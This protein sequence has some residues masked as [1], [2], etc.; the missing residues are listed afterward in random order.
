MRLAADSPRDAT[1]ITRLLGALRPREH[2]VPDAA[3][4]GTRH[5]VLPRP[6]TDVAAALTVLSARDFHQT[7][8]WAD[9]TAPA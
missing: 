5:G 8:R 6:A 4:N 3:G 9:V 7:V 2:A 1:T